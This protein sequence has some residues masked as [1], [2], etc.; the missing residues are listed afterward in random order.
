[1]T[2]WFIFFA[3]T[4]LC[5]TLLSGV[6]EYQYLGDASSTIYGLMIWREV[7]LTDPLSF[8]TSIPSAG[9]SFIRGVWALFSWD[10]AF[11]TGDLIIFRYF[12]WCISLGLIITFIMTITRR[13]G[14]VT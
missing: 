13:A 6:I 12:G 1:M 3:V 4:F 5:A 8:I 9:V 14:V 7:S 11:L 2:K 10:Y